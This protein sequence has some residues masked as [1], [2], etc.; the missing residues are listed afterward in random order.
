M[1]GPLTSLGGT[2][3]IT[4]IPF[5]PLGIVRIVL[6]ILRVTVTIRVVIGPKVAVVRVIDQFLS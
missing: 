4:T 6:E 3:L 2:V 5:E 1:P